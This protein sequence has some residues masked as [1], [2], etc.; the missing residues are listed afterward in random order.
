MKSMRQSLQRL[1]G[2]LRVAIAL[3]V[4]LTVLP[5]VTDT[6]TATAGAATITI[7]SLAADGAAPLPFARFQVVDSNGVDYG[8]LESVPGS[9]QAVFT[10][11][12]GAGDITFTITEETPPACGIAEAAKTVKG[13]KDG[14]D[15][16][17]E[18]KTSFDQNCGLG[19]VS[20]YAYDCPAGVDGGSTSYADYQSACTSTID[21]ETFNIAS[22]S[23]SDGPWSVVTGAWGISGRAPLV[24]LNAGDYT[25]SDAGNDAPVVFCA[26]YVLDP[27]DQ[28]IVPQADKTPVKNGAAM[29]T[30]ANDRVSCDF[31]RVAA[32]DGSSG[33]GNAAD[34][35]DGN[36]S[37]NGSGDVAPAA[38]GTASV[39]IH[40]SACPAGYKGND[41]Y[42][43]C[44]GNGMADHLISISGPGAYSDSAT[45]ATPATPGPGIAKFDS[46]AAGSYFISEDIPGDTDTYYVYC[47]KAD[48]TDAVD[49]TYNDSNA[50][51]FDITL[52]K[53]VHV[54]CDFSIVPDLQF[55]PATITLLK[56]TCDPGY[57]TTGKTYNDFKADCPSKTNGV[58]FSLSVQGGGAPTTAKTGDDGEGSAIFASLSPATYT[59]SE[60]IGGEFSAPRVYCSANGGGWAKKT[61]SDS[62]AATFTIDGNGQE[63]TC[64]WFNVPEPLAGGGSLT[65][66]NWQ[67][68][69]GLT[70]GYYDNCFGNPVSG[71]TFGLA[72]P[73]SFST[74]ASTGAKGKVTFDTLSAGSYTVTETPPDSPRTAVYVVVCTRDGNDFAKTYDDSTGLR[75]NFKLPAGAA[76][77]CDWYNVPPA[78]PAP[79]VTATATAAPAPSAKGS[80]VVEKFFCQGKSSNAY[81]WSRDCTNYGAG[82]DFTLS[83][84]SGG[85]TSSGS[86][87][88][89]GELTFASLANA[90]YSLEE[91][92]GSWCHAEADHVDASGN[93]KVLNGGKTTVYIYNC[94]KKTA[95]TLPSTGVGPAPSAPSGGTLMEIFGV[96]S[97]GFLM[98]V[99]RARGVKAARVLHR[100]NG[101]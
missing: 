1:S 72:G 6:A 34:N 83:A 3:L 87:G 59:V 90:T 39:E 30:I 27:A 10:V 89:G 67:C 26:S 53:G 40:L 52:K 8:K 11:D 5:A 50:E 95:I 21:G 93:L 100:E 31:F 24:G 43:D 48:N 71:T 46:L 44:H 68:P 20:V 38:G 91:T 81:N 61:L 78:P 14:D 94:T 80:I 60:D 18:F 33:N 58:T 16:A 9:G 66:N 79:T 75:I 57:D 7:K 70:S 13:L 37:G 41:F 92:N 45:T 88:A 29:V 74:T 85:A 28:G 55:T 63:I 22:S 54:V 51:G 42:D 15:K 96:A 32:S 65:I 17:V 98:A 19:S 4:I 73:N 82:A 49:F 69:A 35:G 2:S 23:G 77:V 56:Y 84:I 97:L 76:V 25:V 36:A 47:S 101:R 64:R 86:T 62:G 12:P 99:R